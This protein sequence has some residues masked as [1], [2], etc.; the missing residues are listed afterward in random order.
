MEGQALRAC[1][2]GATV[3]QAF[4]T[5][6]TERWGLPAGW[7]ERAATAD[8]VG[9][10]LDL[11]EMEWILQIRGEKIVTDSNRPVTAEFSRKTMSNRSL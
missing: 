7:T 5:A 6:N 4:D 10:I 1:A 2:P 11:G 3:F 9:R 8:D